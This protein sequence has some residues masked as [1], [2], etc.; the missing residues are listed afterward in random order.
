MRLLTPLES[1]YIS[2]SSM[3]PYLYTVPWAIGL[4]L[5]FYEVADVLLPNFAIPVGCI[6]FLLGIYAGYYE[7]QDPDSIELPLF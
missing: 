7:E 6:G 4:T 2:G 1:Q 5:I 3:Q